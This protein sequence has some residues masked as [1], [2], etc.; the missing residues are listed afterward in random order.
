VVLA[1]RSFLIS[2]NELKQTFCPPGLFNDSYFSFFDIEVQ[3]LVV[4][5]TDMDEA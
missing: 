1:G 3:L 2:Y 5:P 4:F